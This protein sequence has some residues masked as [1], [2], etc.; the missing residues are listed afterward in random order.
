MPS[1]IAPAGAGNSARRTALDWRRWLPGVGLVVGALAILPPYLGPGLHVAHR[2]EIADHVVPGLVVLATSAAALVIGR[3]GRIRP[4]MLVAGLV[5]VLAGLWM[6]MTHVPLVA[7]ATRGEAPW[8]GTLY[9]LTAAVAVLV[10]GV[11]W[12]AAHWRSMD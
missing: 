2:V 11:V 6:T 12:A 4:S 1:P 8:G 9:H 3:H 5:I 10:L 7:Q